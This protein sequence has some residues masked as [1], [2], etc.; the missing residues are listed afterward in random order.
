MHATWSLVLVSLGLGVQVNQS[1]DCRTFVLKR[2]AESVRMDAVAITEGSTRGFPA[3]EVNGTRSGLWP[4]GS[5]MSGDV[6]S[7][8]DSLMFIAQCTEGELR[9]PVRR[10]DGRER[11]L[12]SGK[13]AELARTDMRVNVVWRGGHRIFLL[14]GGGDREP[15][16][17]HDGL[18]E[19]R[20]SVKCQEHELLDTPYPGHVGRMRRLPLEPYRQPF[21][22]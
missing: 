4:F 5:G 12:P 3:N 22:L 16:A 1:A 21:P 20:T 15:S 13:V 11:A 19:W 17:A 6:I 7:R 10:P 14:S 18:L 8:H 2:D 9:I